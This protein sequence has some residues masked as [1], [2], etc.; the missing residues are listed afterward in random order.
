MSKPDVTT[1]EV[2]EFIKYRISKGEYPSFHEIMVG[3][4]IA[5]SSVVAYHLKKLTEAG[6]ITRSSQHRSIRLAKAV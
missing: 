2:F 1:Q 6:L 4:E 3:C 5:S